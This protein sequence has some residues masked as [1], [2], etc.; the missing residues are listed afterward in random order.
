MKSKNIANIV[1]YKYFDG[2]EVV[3]KSTIFYRNGD[4]VSGD[5]QD[6]IDACQEVATEL[7][8]TSGN[9]FKEMINKNIVH[10][11]SGLEFT[12]NYSRFV[13]ES[14][15]GAAK[16]VTS[17]ASVSS[18]TAVVAN[19]TS[20]PNNAE[21]VNSFDSSIEDKN[22]ATNTISEPKK[23]GFFTRFFKKPIRR[24]VA[25]VIALGCALGLYGC[26][27]RLTKEGQM[28]DSNLPDK[29][30]SDEMLDNANNAVVNR[31]LVSGD[32]DLYDDYSYNELLQVT[33]KKQQKEAMESL[34]TFLNDFNGKFANAHKEAGSDVKAAL[35]FDEAVAL[36]QAYNDF[37]RNTL[38]AYF[39]GADIRADKMTRAY[40]DAS[41][42]LMGAYIIEDRQNPVDVTPLLE[43]EEAKE[44]YNRYHEMFLAAK[45]ATSKED[46]QAKVS[47]FYKAVKEDF[48]ITPEIRTEGIA[49]ADAYATIEA[50]K[51]SVTPMIA[52]AETMFQNLEVD[53]TLNDGEIDFLND[54][55]LCNYAE[56]TF[57]RIET[58]AL[59]SD[60]DNTNPLYDQYRDALI[61]ELKE[62][63]QY[64]I[65]DAHRNLMSL[66]AFDD[67]VNWHFEIVEG[68]SVEGGYSY[69]TKT[70][71]VKTTRT[72]TKTSYRTEETRTEKPIPAS[73][74]QK[75][76]DE[77]AKENSEAKA[78]GEKAA[79]E[80]QKKMQ[81][82]EDKK[83]EQVREE[84]KKDEADFQEKIDR[85]NE[86]IDKNNSDED[87]SNDKPVNESDFGS[88]DVH[89]DDQHS[90]GQGNL[91][92]SVKDLTTD[93]TGDQT[94]D[95]LPDPNATG[96]KFDAQVSYVNPANDA[97]GLYQIYEYSEPASV[98]YE[99]AVD[100]YVENLANATSEYEGS[101]QYTLN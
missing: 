63:N 38:K 77:I 37:G 48:P 44:F 82:E 33:N 57:E 68:Y 19:E 30:V 72:E 32:N 3:T 96:A 92:D 14:R 45:E 73:E 99:S 100:S 101:Y 87:K 27:A 78:S 61:K 95:P 2:K 67:A 25:G 6:G 11:M 34:Y 94:N 16:E 41:L 15:K 40:K 24:I 50:Y 97:S 22:V 86:Q 49:H 66:Q 58:I 79:A 62:N 71:Q 64:V 8:I 5:F 54:I 52:A 91:N 29:S 28:K 13:K 10:V 89:F 60:E 46:M 42:Q 9:A 20:T 35:T 93:S 36:Q 84:V 31:N 65:D 76:D 80:N 7:K 26:A 70:T 1:F 18:D 90:D 83:A 47:A 81:E 53:V 21:N 88:H 85:A 51:L 69:S 43:T 74:K 98:S 17:A 56:R 75:I 12:N 59:S 55:G 23:E 4:I 39:N